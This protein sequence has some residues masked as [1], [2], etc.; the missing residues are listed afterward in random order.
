MAD[1]RQ[2]LSYINGLSTRKRR[3]DATGPKK[4]D[5]HDSTPVVLSVRVPTDLAAWV[6]A[7]AEAEGLSPNAWLL[8]LL[9]FSR[10]Q[11]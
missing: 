5:Y 11:A 9:K 7:Q 6:R 2:P 10:S 8:N 4:S 3:R 1:K